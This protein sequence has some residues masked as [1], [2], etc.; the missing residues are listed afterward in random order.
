MFSSLCFKI[1]ISQFFLTNTAT[2]KIKMLLILSRNNYS[3]VKFQLMTGIKV[4]FKQQ[5]IESNNVGNKG[6][7]SSFH[8]G[9][10]QADIT[11]SPTLV[12]DE[13]TSCS[14]W[15]SKP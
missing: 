9:L 7:T 10:K 13:E 8:V 4:R 11:T 15:T 12:L 2:I 6:S 5:H 3:I 1:H 14:G